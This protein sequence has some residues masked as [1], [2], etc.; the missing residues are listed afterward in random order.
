LRLNENIDPLNPAV[1]SYIEQVQPGYLRQ[2]S[3]FRDRSEAWFSERIRDRS[4]SSFLV[5]LLRRN[6]STRMPK[7]P[8][9]LSHGSNG[10][11]NWD[12]A[13]VVLG[14]RSDSCSDQI[15]AR[16]THLELETV[17]RAIES[18]SRLPG[19]ESGTPQ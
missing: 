15:A 18:I 9:P 3:S 8:K 13:S 4:R 19:K 10:F 16:H 11:T 1:N 12:S 7:Q 5:Q 14:D 6:F 17:R 2:V